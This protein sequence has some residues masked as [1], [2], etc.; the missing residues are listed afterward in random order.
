MFS[1]TI[2][3]GIGDAWKL[4]VIVTRHSVRLLLDPPI[5]RMVEQ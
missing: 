3:Q 2:I 4:L 5:S 1:A